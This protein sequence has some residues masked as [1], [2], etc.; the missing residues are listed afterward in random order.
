[1]CYTDVVYRT[2]ITTGRIEF[3]AELLARR[4][5][6]DFVRIGVAFIEELNIES[7]VV[8]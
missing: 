7:P 1:L 8:P 3:P 4:M 6:V 2:W 5:R